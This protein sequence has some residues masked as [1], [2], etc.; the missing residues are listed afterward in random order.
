MGYNSCDMRAHHG[1]EHSSRE[2]HSVNFMK[3]GI[4]LRML[5]VAARWNASIKAYVLNFDVGYWDCSMLA[6]F[7]RS[8]VC[9]CF[10]SSI[11]AH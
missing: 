1:I 4:T 5:F 3:E 11:I 6:N 10:V 8:T 2:I 9:A 7:I